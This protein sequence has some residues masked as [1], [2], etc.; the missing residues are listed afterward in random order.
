MIRDVPVSAVCVGVYTAVEVNRA[1]Q[2]VPLS[3]IFRVL[4]AEHVVNLGSRCANLDP[5]LERG[6]EVCII[7]TLLHMIREV[8]CVLICVVRLVC[9]N[10][11]D[12]IL[13]RGATREVVDILIVWPVRCLDV[14]LS[15]GKKSYES[16]C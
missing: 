4:E 12:C 8:H 16:R 9:F 1:P 14:P 6:V 13:G 3:I 10:G 5:R 2:V 15:R 11:S 7:S